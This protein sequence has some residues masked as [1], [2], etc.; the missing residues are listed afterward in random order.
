MK[1]SS[2]GGMNTGMCIT[3]SITPHIPEPTCEAIPANAIRF[4]VHQPTCE[5]ALVAPHV[6][7]SILTNVPVLPALQVY[8]SAFA[9]TIAAPQV[10]DPSHENISIALHIHGS[11]LTNVLYW[12]PVT[13]P[14]LSADALSMNLSTLPTPQPKQQFKD[15]ISRSKKKE[16]IF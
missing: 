10:H 3:P 2:F 5:D 7:G 1:I 16:V 9:P 11:I 6:L 13:T 15:P 8:R 4:Q 12:Q 14:T